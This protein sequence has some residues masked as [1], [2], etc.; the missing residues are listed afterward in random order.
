MRQ[1]NLW[2]KFT[3]FSKSFKSK[4]KKKKKKN[5][6]WIKFIRKLNK[7]ELEWNCNKMRYIR[8]RFYHFR[9]RQGH[10]IGKAYG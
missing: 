8:L 5:F 9:L 10:I 6:K 4:K 7:K 2:K 3:N 1:K